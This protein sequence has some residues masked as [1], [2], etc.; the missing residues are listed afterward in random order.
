MVHQMAQE[1]DLWHRVMVYNTWVT[2]TQVKIDG[3]VL[4]T[5]TIIIILHIVRLKFY[6]TNNTNTGSVV[7][8]C[9]CANLVVQAK[10]LIKNP[11]A[12]GSVCICDPICENP[13]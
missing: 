13:T 12:F 6:D 5:A 3:L 2:L 9:D 11:S 7:H 4:V 1:M 10:N 8:S